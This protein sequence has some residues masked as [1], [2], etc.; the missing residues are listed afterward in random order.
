MTPTLRWCRTAALLI[1]LA[2]PL[3]CENANQ[4]VD[5]RNRD[6]E[7]TQKQDVSTTSTTQAPQPSSTAAVPTSA[8]GGTP[9]QG[10][11]VPAPGPT[12]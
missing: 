8:P 4:D 2:S 7:T 12:F 10:S 9:G 11:D 5:P 6:D 3:A 1:L